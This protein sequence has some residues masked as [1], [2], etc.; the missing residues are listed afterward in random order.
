MSTGSD[1]V[2]GVSS[3]GLS[4][5]QAAIVVPSPSPGAAAVPPIAIAQVSGS[6][7]RRALAAP[8]L[9]EQHRCPHPVRPPLLGEREP[10]LVRG[11]R[12]KSVEVADGLS[13]DPILD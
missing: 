5:V 12:R 11:R 2:C 6:G 1:I 8:G 4:C 9:M 3:M 13:A 7:G 10:F